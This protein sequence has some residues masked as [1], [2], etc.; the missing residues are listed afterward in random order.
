MKQQSSD[1]WFL[2]F[3]EWC[4]SLY[5][6]AFRHEYRD[7][8]LQT[9]RDAIHDGALQSPRALSRIF[10]DLILSL[11]KENLRMLRQELAKRTILF[12]TF[13]LTAICSMFALAM[14]ATVQHAL[15]SGANDPQLQMADDAVAQLEQG[16]DAAFVVG[17]RQ[18]NMARSLSPFLIVY[19]T[20]GEPVAS[21]AQLSGHAPTPP[22]GVF[23]Y[24]TDHQRNVLTWQPQRGVRIAAVVQPF[25]GQHAGF[26]LAG[27]SLRVVE[28]REA[29]T[30]KMVGLAWLGTMVVVLLAT[31]GFMFIVRKEFAAAV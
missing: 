23:R 7:P 26:V 8:M 31:A 19:D 15:R 10:I 24:A 12:Q 5:P 11:C 29:A 17:S 28:D 2:R 4:L 16:A 22:L 3:Y 30:L 9:M 25:A 20:N 1:S 6:P 21:A 27:R 13:L 18:V 14:Y